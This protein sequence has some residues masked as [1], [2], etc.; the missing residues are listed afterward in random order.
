MSR[1]KRKGLCE[2]QDSESD[3]VQFGH[4]ILES[5]PKVNVNQINVTDSVTLPLP[6]QGCQP[7][8]VAEHQINDTFCSQVTQN[9]NLPKF[10]D[11]TVDN[12]LLY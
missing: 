6:V 1:I 7:T 3:G 4:T 12:G 8:D 9:I 5:L 2:A 10:K 11:Y